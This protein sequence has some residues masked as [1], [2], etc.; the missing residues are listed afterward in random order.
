MI[1]GLAGAA[2]TGAAVVG[3]IVAATD[4]T[5]IGTLAIGVAA[6]VALIVNRQGAKTR[7]ELQTGGRHARRNRSGEPSFA[8]RLFGR[9]DVLDRRLDRVEA[10]SLTERRINSQRHATNVGRL[11]VL[12]GTARRVEERLGHLEERPACPSPP[13]GPS[14]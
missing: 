9:L 6:M 13:E 4:Y 14:S 1:A 2:L 3:L 8:D 12:E 5:G 11:A 7:E 10:H